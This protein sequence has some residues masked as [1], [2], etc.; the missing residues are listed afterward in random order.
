MWFTILEC[1]FKA[2]KIK[3]SLTKFAHAVSLLPPDVFPQVSDVISAAFI[4][5]TPYDDLKTALLQNLQPSI[6][7]R[8]KE[9][10]S[11]EELGD[12]KP[13]EIL[14]RMKQ[15]LGHKYRSFDADLPICLLL[16]SAPFSAPRTA[17]SLMPSLS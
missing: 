9:L 12:E 10:F 15:L 17:Y 7:T 16:F 2:S 11:K 5:N 14:R 4:S 8:L 3:N 6:A 13:T 1:G